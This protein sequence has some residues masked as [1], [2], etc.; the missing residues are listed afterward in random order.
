MQLLY[1][2]RNP[3]K[4]DAM[5]RRLEKIQIRLIGLNDLKEKGILIH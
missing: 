4:L 3:A 1:A 5:R 2:T